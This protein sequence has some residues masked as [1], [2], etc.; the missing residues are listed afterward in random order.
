MTRYSL[1]P[2]PVFVYEWMIS[3]RRWQGYAQRSLFVAI[4]LAALI[5]VWSGRGGGTIVPSIRGLAEVGR[6]YFNAAVVTQLT[7]VLLVAPAATAGAICLDRSRGT[8][9]HLL[10]TDLSSSEIV[11]GKFAARLVPVISMIAC[12]F[13]VLAFLT[14][15]G[16]IGGDEVVGAFLVTISV[17]VLG[18]SLA[19][20]MSLWV[21]K[22]HEALLGTYAIWGLWLLSPM[23][24]SFVGGI[25]G[26]TLW[27]FHWTFDPFELT[28]GAYGRG[29]S[30]G[31]GD[32]LLFLSVT[33][34][35]SAGLAILAVI[36]LRPVCSR[37]R[38]RRKWPLATR[39]SLSMPWIAELERLAARLPAP[40]LDANPVLWREWHRNRP[41]PWARFVVA[42]FVALSITFSL[43]AIATGTRGVDQFVNGFVVS[44]GLLMLSVTASTSLAEERARGSLD[45]L[46]A[47]PMSTRQIVLGKWLGA[48]RRVPALTVLPTLVALTGA[49]WK[50]MKWPV[51]ILMALYVL[52]VGAAV[53]SLGVA[54]ATWCSRLGRAV[55]LTVLTF[56]A[57]TVGWMFLVMAMTSPHPYGY[58]LIAGSPFFGPVVI[59]SFQEWQ[60]TTLT[61]ASV[62]VCWVV[63]YL[64]AASVLLAATLATFDH[65]LGR[66]KSSSDREPL[67]EP[68]LWPD[69][70]NQAVGPD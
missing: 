66:V 7:L 3:S 24:T 44:V 1:G 4:L 42:L 2:G 13:P 9:T 68:N 32:H 54:L 35:I 16:G 62:V 38:V 45:V 18:S 27:T 14:L 5:V 8:L 70:E 55:G 31:L 52:A 26:V 39:L 34:A 65:C 60:S 36:R 28:V 58:L 12:T 25:L 59:T 20:A 37:E 33:W 15:L 11:L 30:V 47:T 50:G 57:V 49:G 51:A 6:A 63:A 53:T 23:M 40:S 46:M 22:T 29:G 41:S 10:V 19:L 67:R 21:G 43:L 48:F 56:A 64:I 69:L 61:D 17:A